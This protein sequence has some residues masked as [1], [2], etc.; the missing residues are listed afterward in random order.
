MFI[1]LTNL[2]ILLRTNCHKLLVAGFLVSSKWCLLTNPPS[3][4]H[5]NGLVSVFT[6]LYYIPII[7]TTNHSYLKENETFPGFQ[8][9]NVCLA[10]FVWSILHKYFQKQRT[11]ECAKFANRADKLMSWMSFKTR[12]KSLLIKSDRR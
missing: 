3:F 4:F 12:L 6:L 9:E 2:F 10:L 1:L 11:P 5:F 7:R 8:I